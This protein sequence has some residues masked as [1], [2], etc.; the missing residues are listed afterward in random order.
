MVRS[1]FSFCFDCLR[2]STTSAMFS[3][4]FEIRSVWLESL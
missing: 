1:D 3:L 2:V 4:N